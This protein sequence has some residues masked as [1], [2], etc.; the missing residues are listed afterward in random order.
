MPRQIDIPPTRRGLKHFLY[1]ARGICSPPAHRRTGAGGN[2]EQCRDRGC[3]TGS[4]DSRRSRAV[5]GSRRPPPRRRAGA[6]RHLPRGYRREDEGDGPLRRHHR[7]GVRRPRPAR[8]HLR[9]GH[10]A[11]LPRLD[12]GER[13]HQLPPHHGGRRRA[14]RHRRP[15]A[16]LPPPLRL[17]RAARRPRAHGAR[18]RHRPAG[19]PH[20]G[21]GARATTPT[22]STAPRPGSPTA[23]TAPAWRSWSRPIPMPSPATRA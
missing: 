6:R 17:G 4:A 19:D 16:G 23:S 15:A 22:S 2:G 14:L 12:V 11:A 20:H 21:A 8:H 10:R 9:Q 3:R 1:Q 5:P 18:L 7:R 13:P